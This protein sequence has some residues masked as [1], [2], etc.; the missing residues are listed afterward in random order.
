MPREEGQRLLPVPRH[1]HR[2]QRPEKHLAVPT[3]DQPRVADR[4]RTEILLAADKAPYS[5]LERESRLGKLIVAERVFSRRFE[6]LDPR[7]HQWVI[8]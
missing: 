8:R 6:M 3:P 4:D 1:G 5:L 7:A 2:G